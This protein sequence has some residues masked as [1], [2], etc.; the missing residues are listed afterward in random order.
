MPRYNELQRTVA[1]SSPFRYDSNF[2]L[3][4]FVYLTKPTLLCKFL[5]HVVEWE[6]TPRMFDLG[7]RRKWTVIF[8]LTL[9]EKPLVLPIR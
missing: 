3:G 5:R 4:L 2:R 7:I 8:T 6:L 9:K 1:A